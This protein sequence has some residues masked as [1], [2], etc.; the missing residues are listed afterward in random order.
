VGEGED[1]NAVPNAVQEVYDRM[2][3]LIRESGRDDVISALAWLVELGG[4]AD[5]DLIRRAAYIEPDMTAPDEDLLESAEGLVD[6]SFGFL[7]L[8]KSSKGQQKFR[9]A[10]ETCRDYFRSCANTSG[11]P[12]MLAQTS[13]TYLS[14]ERSISLWTGPPGL[15]WSSAENSLFDAACEF[16]LSDMEGVDGTQTVDT[17]ERLLNSSGPNI[18]DFIFMVA[19]LVRQRRCNKRQELMQE[20]PITLEVAV[21]PG[22]VLYA[23]LKLLVASCIGLTNDVRSIVCGSIS[24]LG[25][26]T[27]L[28]LCAFFDRESF[29][30]ELF[31][32]GP[33]IIPGPVSDYFR[34][35]LHFTALAPPDS[36]LR[37][38][39]TKLLLDHGIQMIYGVPGSGTLLHL[40]SPDVPLA[41]LLT[42]G[43]AP[44]GAAVSKQHTFLLEKPHED[45][46]SVAR[47]VIERGPL[48]DSALELEREAFRLRPERDLDRALVSVNLAISL[49]ARFNQT[50]D[51]RLL[52]EAV[53]I[54][55]RAIEDDA[56]SPSDH[57]LLRVQLVRIYT[58]PGYLSSSISTAVQFLSEAVVH[59]VGLIT[60]F[61]AFNDALLF[62]VRAAFSD[63]ENVRL[64]A[65]YQAIIEVVPEVGG[66][67]LDE[68]W[69]LCRRC[70]AGDIPT[71]A[72]IQAV[73][74][75]DVALG[76]TLLEQGRAVRWSH[77]LAMRDPQLD[78]LTHE[79]KTRLQTL[80]KYTSFFAEHGKTQQSSLTT[81]DREPGF[82][83]QLQ[84]LLKEIRASPGLLRFMRGPSYSELAQ[85]SSIHPVIV[86]FTDG[87]AC[88]AL[89]L[90]SASAS[91]AHFVL[92]NIPT[93]VYS[94]VGHVMGDLATDQ[95]RGFRIK[96]NGSWRGGRYHKCLQKLW[97]GTVKPILDCLSLQVSKLT[98][99]CL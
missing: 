45:M 5:T 91:P 49:K 63:E 99:T 7:R 33:H 55:T 88:H 6:A 35:V 73:K 13:L 53:S 10:H 2:L 38:K 61:H 84:L 30:I 43:G 18:G 9:L 68:V 87:K 92:D 36:D 78:G 26:S 34:T 15:R 31:K 19:R 17:L 20:L 83:S 98:F 32:I 4:S 52:Y 11:W 24:H 25:W 67:A 41:G 74:A 81:R 42:G 65:V 62:C 77:I 57:V 46:Q 3:A 12:T 44:L 80:L 89:A 75:N 51:I 27:A 1:S 8:E 71:Q 21:E 97:V 95:V 22:N 93:S 60:H 14:F 47:L 37:I 96:K 48:L 86:M 23:S 29:A 58:S 90:S 66:A 28:T 50:G 72:L 64:L 94:F 85:V 59:R 70:D 69:R 54:C 76:L 79:W 16:L 82:Y 39:I 40:I 56:V